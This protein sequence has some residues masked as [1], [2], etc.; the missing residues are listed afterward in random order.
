MFI[1]CAEEISSE[2]QDLILK[3]TVTFLLQYQGTKESKYF[4]VME[5]VVFLAF[6]LRND[7]EKFGDFLIKKMSSF[8]HK[9]SSLA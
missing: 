7:P 5:R 8:L 4:N 1:N 2:H 3:I 9:D 6:H